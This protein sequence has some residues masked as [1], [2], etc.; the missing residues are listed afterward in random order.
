MISRHN[1]PEL[2][3]NWWLQSQNQIIARQELSLPLNSFSVLGPSSY[4]YQ[5]ELQSSSF[6]SFFSCVSE[7]FSVRR[8]VRY[9]RYQNIKNVSVTNYRNLKCHFIQFRCLGPKVY[10][11][12]VRTWHWSLNILYFQCYL[13]EEIFSLSILMSGNMAQQNLYKTLPPS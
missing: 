10:V 6:F 4:N 2:S 13:S 5:D 3:Q 7:E 9:S 12:L 8:L 1:Q 11:L